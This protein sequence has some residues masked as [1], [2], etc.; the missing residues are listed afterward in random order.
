MENEYIHV[1]KNLILQ[2]CMEKVSL[3]GPL[4]LP[5]FYASEATTDNISRESCQ[6]S[7]HIKASMCR[8]IYT[9]IL[10]GRVFFTLLHSFLFTLITFNTAYNS[11]HIYI[12]RS[13]SL[14]YRCIIYHCMNEA[15]FI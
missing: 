1:T 9:Y 13:T 2:T 6:F 10:L 12:S 7:R 15:S 11:F 4:E 8:C 5:Y 3:S 14:V